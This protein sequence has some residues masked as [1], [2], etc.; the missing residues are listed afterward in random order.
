LVG[1]SKRS[2]SKEYCRRPPPPPF[3]V[4]ATKEGRG[5]GDAVWRGEG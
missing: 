5:A 3:I 4:G 2:C 1:T